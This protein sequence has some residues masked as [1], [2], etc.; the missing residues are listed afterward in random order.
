[1]HSKT[2]RDS[3]LEGLPRLA[4]PS[5][6]KLNAMLWTSRC[7]ALVAFLMLGGAS[8]AQAQPENAGVDFVYGSM[9]NPLPIVFGG[10]DERSL[11]GINL[12][13][14]YAIGHGLLLGGQL[15]LAHV[16]FNDDA[17]TS[18]GNLTAEL[19]YRLTNRPRSSSW[20]DTS[21]SIGTADNNGDGR[22]AAL[23]FAVFTMADPGLYAPDTNTVRAMYRHYY[24]DPK[25]RFEFQGGFQYI[26]F[27]DVDDIT[28]VPLT[29]GVRAELG[30]RI[31]ALGR[32]S[33]FWL[34]DA[35]DGEDDF[36]HMLEAGFNLRKVGRGEVEILLYFPLDDSYR[37]VLEV[38]GLNVGFTTKL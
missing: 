31:E 17:A 9:N 38:W 23:T 19:S 13:G 29:L 22:L 1:M 21:L 33:T 30:P 6:G 10:G 4:A 37:D 27:K 28:R 15:P 7:L 18:L 34:L 24:G 26:L 35:E 16:R 11:I 3:D 12:H 5:C 25:L 14:Q 8:V 20:V 2:T 36:L 32:F